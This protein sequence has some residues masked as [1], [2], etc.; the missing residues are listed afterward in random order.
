ML[1]DGGESV[2][3]LSLWLR[4]FLFHEYTV[5]VPMDVIL[6]SFFFIF[7]I[8]ILKPVRHLVGKSL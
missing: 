1:V 2:L 4:H 7:F 3:L 6:L 8:I 5:F